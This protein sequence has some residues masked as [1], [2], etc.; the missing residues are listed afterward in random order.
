[1][2]ELLDNLAGSMGALSPYGWTDLL[3]KFKVIKFEFDKISSCKKASV[4]YKV[5]AVPSQR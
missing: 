3:V 4:A 1:M 2:N 5:I